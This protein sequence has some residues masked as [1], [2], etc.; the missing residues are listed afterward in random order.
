MRFGLTQEEAAQL[1]GLSHKHYQAIESGRKK[2]IWLETVERLAR[3]Y[4]LSV[5]EILQTDLPS[6]SIVAER[7]P[8]S[9]AHY[10]KR[11]QQNE[12]KRRTGESTNS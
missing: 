11:A 7:P 9:S 8:A 1:T 5:A 6:H 2:Q 3:A 12:V 10:R 4:G